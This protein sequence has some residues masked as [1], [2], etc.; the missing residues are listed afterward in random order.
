MTKLYRLLA[1]IPTG[2]KGWLFELRD[3]GYLYYKGKDVYIYNAV[4]LKNHPKILEDWFEEIHNDPLDWKAGVIGAGDKFWVSV[5]V[6]N[7]ACYSEDE[8]LNIAH[9]INEMLGEVR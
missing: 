9:K 4:A 5:D 2:K 6:E 7:G 3:D 8:A 1:D